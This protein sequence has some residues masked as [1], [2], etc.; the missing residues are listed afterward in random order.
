MC[1]F[2]SIKRLVEAILRC[3]HN[4]ESVEGISSR[5]QC[6]NG[7]WSRFVW[8]SMD[9]VRS[10]CEV[11]D[12]RQWQPTSRCGWGM[13][14]KVLNHFQLANIFLDEPLMWQMLQASQEVHTMLAHAGQGKVH[15]VSSPKTVV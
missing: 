6:R 7:E 9:W 10:E 1:P 5:Y 2:K 12:S 4:K 11:R 8:Y 15:N 13:L 3:G 14:Q